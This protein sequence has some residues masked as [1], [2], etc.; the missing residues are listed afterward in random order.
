MS[1]AWKAWHGPGSASAFEEQAALTWLTFSRMDRHPLAHSFAG[2]IG[3]CDHVTPFCASSTPAAEV[4][5]CCVY[6][7]P[8]GA[9]SAPAAEVIGRCDHVTPL[10]ALSAPGAELIGRRDYVTPFCALSALQL[11]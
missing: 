4:I 11:E 8:F 5:G 9:L 3:C 10:C 6:V 2:V 7:T 1:C